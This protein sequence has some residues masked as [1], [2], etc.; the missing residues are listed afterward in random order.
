[1]TVFGQDGFR[2]EL[3]ALNI[4]FLVAY[5]HDFAVISPCGDFQA[6][7]QRCAFDGQ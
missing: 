2:M 5:A 4:E 6:I 3:H 1:M 7:R